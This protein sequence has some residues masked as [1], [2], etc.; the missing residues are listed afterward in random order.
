MN[1]SRKRTP[2]S[3]LVEHSVPKHYPVT[4]YDRL[5]PCDQAYVRAVVGEMRKRPDAA[6]YLVA[7]ALIATSSLTKSRAT[8][9]RALKEML[10]AET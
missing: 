5:P 1:R 2:P 10:H 4:W 3:R 7:D 8:V 6:P 9:A